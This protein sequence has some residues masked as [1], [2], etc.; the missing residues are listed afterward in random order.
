MWS[1]SG[2]VI[3]SMCANNYMVGVAIR[4]FIS[5]TITKIYIVRKY[6]LLALLIDC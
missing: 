2:I 3:Y 4:Q 1:Y 5:I 6:T